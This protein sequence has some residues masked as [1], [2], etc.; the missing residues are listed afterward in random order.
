MDLRR[1][2]ISRECALRLALAPCAKFAASPAGDRHCWVRVGAAC[3]ITRHCGYVY[4]LHHPYSRRDL[5]EVLR[6][7]G[8]ARGTSVAPRRRNATAS[9][10][11]QSGWRTWQDQLHNW[12]LFLMRTIGACGSALAK[13][14]RATSSIQSQTFARSPRRERPLRALGC[15]RPQGRR[16][17]S[18]E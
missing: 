15:C 2:C 14:P 10:R 11:S 12:P 7:R 9:R 17:T 5:C 6:G 4:K 13:A 3:S 16:T 18:S 1:N 8:S